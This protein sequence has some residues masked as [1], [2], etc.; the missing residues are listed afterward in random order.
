MTPNQ[1]SGQGTLTVAKQKG[2]V[3]SFVLRAGLFSFILLFIVLPQY[4]RFHPLTYIFLLW[5][6]M[7]KNHPISDKLL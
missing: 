1:N 2:R 4:E 3:G 7:K 6:F 5:I